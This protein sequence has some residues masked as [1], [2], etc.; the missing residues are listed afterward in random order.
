MTITRDVILHALYSTPQQW[1]IVWEGVL[2]YQ[3]RGISN[4]MFRVMK[5]DKAANR[6]ETPPFRVC[7]NFQ[8]YFIKFMM[9]FYS[10][11]SKTN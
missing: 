11:I 9:F 2:V 1:G 8:E 5:D 10:L 3:T 7:F 4:E 6:D